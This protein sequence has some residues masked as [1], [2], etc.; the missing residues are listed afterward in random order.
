MKRITARLRRVVARGYPRAFGVYL[1]GGAVFAWFIPRIPPEVHF[2]AMTGYLAAALCYGVARTEH[3]MRLEADERLERSRTTSQCGI[4][5]H[6][7]CDGRACPTCGEECRAPAKVVAAP[8][9]NK[10]RAWLN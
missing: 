7:A 10:S 8:A 3:G 1:L 6:Y 5:L 2:Y 4:C 9:T